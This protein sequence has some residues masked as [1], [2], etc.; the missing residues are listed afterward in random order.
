MRTA[1]PSTIS[2]SPRRCQGVR[3]RRAICRPHQVHA[4]LRSVPNP[5]AQ[6]ACTSELCQHGM[7][8]TAAY[9]A[10]KATTSK[11]IYVKSVSLLVFTDFHIVNVYKTRVST[12]IKD[13]SG[14]SSFTFCSLEPATVLF[15]KAVSP[16][17]R[18]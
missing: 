10:I 17:V 7:G 4:E 18:K 13:H 16:K 6:H 11:Q 14:F 12:N 5:L 8:A 9:D 2:G 3:G 1:S 15:S